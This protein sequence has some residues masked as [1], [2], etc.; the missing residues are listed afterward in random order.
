MMNETAKTPLSLEIKASALVALSAILYGCLSCLGIKIIDQHF[1]V[2]TML[3]WRFSIATLWMLGWIILS[4][5][6]S[7]LAVCKNHR[8]MLGLSLAV[9][10]YSVASALYF[11][12]CELV[13]T[14]LAMIIFFT[15]PIFVVILSWLVEKKP[16]TKYTMMVLAAIVFG[17]ILLKGGGAVNLSK[18]GIVYAISA[19][20]FFGTYVYGSKYL[21]KNIPSASI[22]I[23]V[24]LGC[25]I[26]FFLIATADHS[27]AYPTTLKTWFYISAMG[28]IATALPIQLLL[29]A[30][31]H[32]HPNKASILSV[33]EPVVTVILGIIVLGETTT[34]LQLI[35]GFIILFSALCIQFERK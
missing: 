14:G 1:S 12:A 15:F 24:C 22:T 19:A 33:L 11:L 30:M 9:I 13:G 35:G 2:P 31:K 6:K 8:L 21:I 32:I 3:F 20:F 5:N 4:Q 25:A 28:V 29:E 34:T 18:L 27:F 17:L 23:L 16:I 10:F 7:L 26:L